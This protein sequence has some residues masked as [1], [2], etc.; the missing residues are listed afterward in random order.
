LKFEDPRINIVVGDVNSEKIY[1]QLSSRA[2]FDIVIDDGSH[3][4]EDILLSFLNY[5][6]MVVPGG[7]YVVED[8]HA[9]YHRPE[10]GISAKRNVLGFFKDLTDVVNFQ[11]WRRE[12]TIEHLLQPYIAA[13]LP[14]WLSGGWV[15]ALEF[16]NSLVAI[17]KSKT[18]GHEKLGEMTV[19]GEIAEVDE[20]PLRVRKLL[21]AARLLT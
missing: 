13:S 2:M 17:R 1:Q 9:V 6:P 15:E 19:T 4:S 14:A 7:L 3:R 12:S 21:A 18:A 5:F 8:T 20:E 10:T 11:F 16:R